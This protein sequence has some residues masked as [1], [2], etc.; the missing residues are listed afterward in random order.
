MKAS[1]AECRLSSSLIKA[2]DKAQRIKRMAWQH[3]GDF[4][5]MSE[6]MAM[7]SS[8]DRRTIEQIATK[9]YGNRTVKG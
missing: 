3:D 7:L 1:S 2:E 9:I 4:V 8:A 5:L 6:Q